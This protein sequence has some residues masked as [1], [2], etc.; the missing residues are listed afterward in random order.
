MSQTEPAGKPGK[1]TST[2]ANDLTLKAVSD[3]PGLGVAV[4]SL[5]GRIHQVN[6][7]ACGMFRGHQQVQVGLGRTLAELFPSPWVDERLNALQSVVNQDRPLIFRCIWRGRRLESAVRWLGWEG[8]P[9]RPENGRVMVFTRRGIS[10]NSEVGEA[11]AVKWAEVVELGR[12]DA[13]SRRELEV[14]A[15]L[16]QGISYEDIARYLKRSRKTVD[17]HRQSIGRKLE[18]CDRITLA[19]LA[20]EAGLELRD[21]SARR[22][23]FAPL[24]LEQPDIEAKPAAVTTARRTA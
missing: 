21:A 12:L 23:R 15:L 8:E 5:D 13:L 9:N 4:L 17:N 10:S 20:T 19:R 2:N 14:L 1:P 24:A 16:A 3:I 6:A 11:L 18:V 7:Q 22:V